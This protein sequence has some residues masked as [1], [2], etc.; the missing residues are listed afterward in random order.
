[1]RKSVVE[2]Q[3]APTNPRTDEGWL[4]LERIA[5][6]EPTG[7]DPAYPIES[8]FTNSGGWRARKE[9]RQVI[10]LVFDKP[11]VLHRIL[12]RF[13]ETE[14]SRTQY[15]VLRSLSWGQPFREIVHQQWNFSPNG[16][17]EE[18]EDYQVELNDVSAL[19][20]D[21]EPEIKAGKAIATLAEWRVA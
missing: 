18:L 15:F 10:R 1:M 2:A 3:P 12:L 16:S 7:E 5:T 11:Q 17:T 21:I 19:E 9:G 14:I 4:D 13:S 20:L 6:V 8:A